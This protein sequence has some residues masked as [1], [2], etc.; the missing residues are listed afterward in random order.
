MPVV[1]NYVITFQS[2]EPMI[3]QLHDRVEELFRKFLSN[4]V[5][6]EKLATKLEKLDL[7]ED[8]GQF[9]KMTE[10]FI[11]KP[12]EDLVKK[13]H[14]EDSTVNE[15]FGMVRNAYLVT[16]QYL[17]HKLPLQNQLL[18]AVSALD[19]AA[20]GHHVGLAAVKTLGPLVPCNLTPEEFNSYDKEVHNFQADLVLHRSYKQNTR[21]DEWWGG[22][23]KDGNYPTLSKVALSV[24]CIFHGPMVESS[25]NTMGDIIDS[26]S[27]NMSTETYSSFQAIK[28]YLKAQNVTALKYFHREDPLRDPFD[29]D[30]CRN[31]KGASATYRGI[32]HD[33]NIEQQ[34][35]HKSLGL[36]PSSDN[37]K[38]GPTSKKAARE[39]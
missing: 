11:G 25:F 21:V 2:K 34:A 6:Q 36:N 1:K 5:K 26:K 23:Y 18:K 15:F 8:N 28:Y 31:I 13:A 9:L 14:K 27:P 22:V 12:A 10:M 24:M 3:Y 20:F 16:G 32:L 35:V 37:Q 39:M 17:Q 33:R 29:S 19:P 30:M 38:A 7:S 4:Y